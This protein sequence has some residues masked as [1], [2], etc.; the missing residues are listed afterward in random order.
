MGWKRHGRAGK[1]FSKIQR[2]RIAEMVLLRGMGVE[3]VAIKAGCTP[4]GVQ[5]IVKQA[6]V[7]AQRLG[8]DQSELEAII[9]DAKPGRGKAML[10]V[11][12]ANY[13]APVKP[14]S[15]TESELAF[16]KWVVRGCLN[17]VADGR[18]FIERL[19]ADSK[20]TQPA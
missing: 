5:K 2:Q 3:L 11:F 17:R 18:T 15:N 1:D 9:K 6:K 19:V 20:G 10:G 7:G 13:G 14:E 8:F 4:R 16:M 12:A